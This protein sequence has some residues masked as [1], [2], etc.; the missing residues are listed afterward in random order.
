M[1]NQSFTRAVV[2]GVVK[3][4]QISTKGS[5]GQDRTIGEV[6]RSLLTTKFVQQCLVLNQEV[7]SDLT[8]AYNQSVDKPI[9]TNTIPKYKRELVNHVKRKS[10][11][12]NLTTSAGMQFDRLRKS[13][14]LEWGVDVFYIPTTFKGVR[15]VVQEFN[16]QF[17]EEYERTFDQGTFGGLINY[18]HG[19]DGVPSGLMGAAIGTESVRQ[20][21]KGTKKAPLRRGRNKKEFDEKF[22]TN[23][24]AIFR[25]GLNSVADKGRL[26]KTL[27]K[28]QM[29]AHQL[30]D[31]QRGLVAGMSMLVTPKL[32]GVN[33]DQASEEAQIQAAYTEAYRR[34]ISPNDLVNMEGSS[35]MLQK[36]AQLMVDSTVVKVSR[37]KNTRIKRPARVANRSRSKGKAD[38]P[39]SRGVKVK[40]LSG[41]TF[42]R[43]SKK[44]TTK[45]RSGGISPFSYIAMINKKLPQTVRK[46]MGAPALENRS[47]R[48]ASSVKVENV[49]QTQQGYPSFGYSY[50]KDPYQ[51]F[52]VGSSGNWSSTQRDPRKLIDRSIR[53]VA[54]EF[55][56]GRFYT[57]RL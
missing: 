38:E 48:F 9:R 13:A 56:L 4:T 47:G 54:A 24:N 45:S 52:E 57:R 41:A 12:P 50:A 23:L 42:S 39:Q 31:G 6:G 16:E 5:K 10:T 53:E 18:D 36:V 43:G 14:K 22:K 55:A 17:S 28:L 7:L 37:N 46:N 20:T 33:L 35:T 29:E 40:K 44:T 21:A 2:Q 25:K 3:N 51:V 26:K 15:D 8:W 27:L 32:K 30:V 11:T 19:G 34:T 49:T 1:S